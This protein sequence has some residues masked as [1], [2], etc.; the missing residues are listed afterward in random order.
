V[1]LDQSQAKGGQK[2]GEGPAEPLGQVVGVGVGVGGGSGFYS[3]SAQ[4]WC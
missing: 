1:W 2:F 4:K 3:V